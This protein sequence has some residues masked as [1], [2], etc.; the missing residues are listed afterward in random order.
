MKHKV[1]GNRRGISNMYVRQAGSP[2]G[3]ASVGRCCV[4]A[5]CLVEVW[6]Y[7]ML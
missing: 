5:F 7:I 3:L 6:H 4:Q 1:K 2:G